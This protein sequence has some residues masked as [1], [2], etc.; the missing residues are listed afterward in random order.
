VTFTVIVDVAVPLAGRLAGFAVTFTE[1][2]GPGSMTTEVV[3][4]RPSVVAVMYAVPATV[5]ADRVT[6]TAPF[7]P[8]VPVGGKLPRLV[9]K[10]TS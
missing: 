9:T 4:L 7:A 10:S 5:P 3:S 2:G 6:V 1:S 8:V